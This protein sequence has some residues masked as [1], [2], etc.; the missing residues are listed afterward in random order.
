[1]VFTRLRSAY[2]FSQLASGTASGS[3]L[4]RGSGRTRSILAIRIANGAAAKLS[5]APILTES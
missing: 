5:K 4:G 2:Q 1:M 3:M